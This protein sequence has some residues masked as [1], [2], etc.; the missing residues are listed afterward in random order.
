MKFNLNPIKVFP[1]LIA[2][3]FL[4][5]SSLLSQIYDDQVIEKLLDQSI[6]DAEKINN[7]SQSVEKKIN[8][9]KKNVASIESREMLQDIARNQSL[10]CYTRI[11]TTNLLAANL[12]LNQKN[13]P[14]LSL[15]TKLKSYKNLPQPL[16]SVIK[17]R[18]ENL[19]S[20]LAEKNKDPITGVIK[21]ATERKRF[22]RKRN[23][24]SKSKELTI[25]MMRSKN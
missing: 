5:P 2:F 17:T 24:S 25:L 18:I 20:R 1:F 3:L 13:K 19:K 8:R 22:L 16:K 23:R 9:I 12:Y 7:V 4:I 15:Y 6:C 21:E 10:D 14:A 11:N